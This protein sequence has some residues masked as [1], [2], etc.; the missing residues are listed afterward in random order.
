LIGLLL[1]GFGTDPSHSSS[2]LV[3]SNGRSTLLKFFKDKIVRQNPQRFINK[4][5]TKHL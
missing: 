3:Y 4:N 1:E 2:M 5:L